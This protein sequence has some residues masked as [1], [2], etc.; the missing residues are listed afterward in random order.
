MLFEHVKPFHFKFRFMCCFLY[1]HFLDA[2]SLCFSSSYFLSLPPLPLPPSLSL[3]P[4]PLPL[5]LSL[6]YSHTIT[7]SIVSKISL[8]A[9]T[10]IF[11]IHSF[12]Y[13][14]VLQTLGLSHYSNLYPINTHQRTARSCLHSSNNVQAVVYGLATQTR[15]LYMYSRSYILH[16]HVYARV[17]FIY[18]LVHNVKLILCCNYHCWS[19]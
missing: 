17:K 18:K 15:C 14:N 5:S 12:I 9:I 11:F 8:L 3:P 4:L 7:C 19:E 13:L 2:L 1:C 10:C 6:P 16:M